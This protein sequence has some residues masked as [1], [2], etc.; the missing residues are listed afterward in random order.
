MK[1]RTFFQYI[2]GI[3]SNVFLIRQSKGNASVIQNEM[4]KQGD[5][6]LSKKLPNKTV[7]IILLESKSYALDPGGRDWW[8]TMECTLS[9][10]IGEIESVDVCYYAADE[11]ARMGRASQR[12]TKELKRAKLYI[13]GM[14]LY[15]LHWIQG[16]PVIEFIS[17]HFD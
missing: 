8:W 14:S 17:P 12:F 4:P 16:K 15:S 6:F 5:I 11:I 7:A 3:V 9:E 13:A 1:R 2:F 10:T